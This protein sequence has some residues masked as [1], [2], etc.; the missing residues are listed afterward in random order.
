MLIFLIG[1]L[2]T[3]IE[4]DTMMIDGLARC[5]SGIL[6][7][8]DS[9]VL[10]FVWSQWAIFRSLSTGQGQTVGADARR[11]VFVD[12]WKAFVALVT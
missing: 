1:G 12:R 11:C 8:D 9:G 4:E 6:C 5:S 10:Q 3:L 7:D 2:V